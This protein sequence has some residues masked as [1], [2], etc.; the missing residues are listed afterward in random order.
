MMIYCEKHDETRDGD[1]ELHCPKCEEDA[2]E[3]EDVI[4]ERTEESVE[5]NYEYEKARGGAR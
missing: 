4:G 3:A 1:Y 2:A 5:R